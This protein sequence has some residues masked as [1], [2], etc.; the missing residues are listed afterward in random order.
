MSEN[1][2]LLGVDAEYFAVTNGSLGYAVPVLDFFGNT[3]DAVPVHKD[4]PSDI[5]P[6]GYDS[7]E[8]ELQNAK[9]TED[10]LPFEVPITP[11]DDVAALVRRLRRGVRK[12]WGI[13]EANGYQMSA[14]P[15]VYFHEEWL[16]TRP[17]LRVLGC[18]PDMCVYDD[19]QEL[20]RPSQDAKSTPWRTGGF[21]VHF[22]MPGLTEDLYLSQSLVMACDAVL[23]LTDVLLEH[24]PN[25]RQRR[26]M[27]GAAGRFRLQPW[28]IEYRTPSSAISVSPEVTTSFLSLAKSLHN[29]FLLG[30]VDGYDLIESL[31]FEAVIKAINAC[32][33]DAALPLWEKSVHTLGDTTF[34]V[35]SESIDLIYGMYTSGG[36]LPEYGDYIMRGWK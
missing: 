7:F 12:A 34:G 6:G 10:G 30:E 35:H 2:A 32:D 9:L 27:Y 28:G 5:Q 18:S 24:T 36:V 8:V 19:G 14:E 1:N 33:A 26:E 22:S 17:E 29:A 4:I 3:N 16:D 11:S 13:A 15:L 20:S 23:G 31:G 21:H 25:G